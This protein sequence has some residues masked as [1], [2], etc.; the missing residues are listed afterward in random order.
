MSRGDFWCTSTVDRCLKAAALFEMAAGEKDATVGGLE[1]WLGL[2]LEG[3]SSEGR[4]DDGDMEPI[5]GVSKKTKNQY[6]NDGKKSVDIN[7]DVGH[8]KCSHAMSLCSSSPA[9]RGL[10]L[11]IGATNNTLRI[12]SCSSRAHGVHPGCLGCCWIIILWLTGL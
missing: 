7:V 1:P 3:P 9:V 8:T 4:A 12:F 10:W 11:V 5:Q 6:L 2:G